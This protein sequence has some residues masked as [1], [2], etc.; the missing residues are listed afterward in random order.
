LDDKLKLP[1]ICTPRDKTRD[2][3][4]LEHSALYQQAYLDKIIKT[5][6]K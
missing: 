1:E 2:S 5:C 6:V 4:I 3:E